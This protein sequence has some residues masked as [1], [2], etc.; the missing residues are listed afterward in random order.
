MKAGIVG[1]GA[2]GRAGAL[3]A[4]QRGS[5][6]ELIL[7]NR[8]PKVS[9]A[10]A[11]DLGY[12]V[13][14]SPA[15]RIVAGDYDA[16]QG[17]GIVVVTAGVNEQSGGATDRKDSAGRLRLLDKNVGVMEAVIPPV[18]AAAPEAVILIA[19]DPPDPL[20]DVVRALAPSSKVFSTGTFLD[21]LRFR[22]HLAEALEVDPRCVRADVL[23]EHGK[24]EVLHWSGAAIGG[25][26]WRGV[27]AQHGM[28]AGRVKARVDDAV[29]HAN[30]N[31]IEGIGAS[32]YGI[33]IVMA[34]LIEAVLRDE[35]LAIPVGT[36]HV[37][38]GVTF[39][40]PS[41]VG[42]A[43][44]ERVLAPQLDAEER[45]ALGR[46][47]STLQDALANS[48]AKKLVGAERR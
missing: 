10:V 17:A 44:V 14:L 12:G 13:P 11:L 27:V 37:E 1:I 42:A 2:V 24:S 40:L 25:V 7:V 20:A 38:H 32:Q 28:D 6:S 46:S 3:A 48:E 36:H 34:R 39:S 5:A 33:G 43:G 30:I 19:T 18:V 26:P 9:K 45:E 4:M 47:I 31:I 22:V 21:S 35:K 15:V 23:G 16:L 41:V 8:N 29:R